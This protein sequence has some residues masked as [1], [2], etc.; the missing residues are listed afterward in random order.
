MQLFPLDAV[1][2]R[3]PVPAV[4]MAS[5]PSYT[6]NILLTPQIIGGITRNTLYIQLGVVIRTFLF[7]ES[8]GHQLNL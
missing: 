2:A 3:V 4:A 5:L 8:R 7:G 6:T 1:I